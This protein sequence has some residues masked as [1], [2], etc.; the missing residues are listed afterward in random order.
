MKKIVTIIMA[1]MVCSISFTDAA[2]AQKK[3][4]AKQDSNVEVFANIAVIDMITI[5]RDAK[6]F[7]HLRK[8]I[9]GY[10]KQLK[11]NARDEDSELQKAN[12]ELARQR[13]IVTPEAFREERKK[14]ESRLGKAQKTLQSRFRVLKIAEQ[15]SEAKI[16]NALQQATVDVAQKRRLILIIRKRAIVFWV[17]ALEITKDVI[18]RLDKKMP[19]FK[20]AVP[21][22][23]AKLSASKRS[24]KKK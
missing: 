18:S 9:S 1:A 11:K 8:Q 7:K 17:E 16:L 24:S 21:K 20:I 13:A 3:K 19:S 5:R 14:F 23:F 22:G 6:A 10:R 12:R 4:T 15:K 2:T